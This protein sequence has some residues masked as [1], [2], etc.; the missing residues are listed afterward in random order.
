MWIWRKFKSFCQ[1]VA[2]LFYRS[3]TTVIEVNKPEV[4]TT[5]EVL[6][7]R[8]G[9]EPPSNIQPNIQPGT[10]DGTSCPE[11]N[12]QLYSRGYAVPEGWIEPSNEEWLELGSEPPSDSC[13]QPPSNELYKGLQFKSTLREKI[14]ALR[15]AL[16]SFKTFS[17]EERWD[18]GG[19]VFFR[20]VPDGVAYVRRKSWWNCF[21]TVT[22]EDRL[23]YE[24]LDK[25]FLDYEKLLRYYRESHLSAT[26]DIYK[27]FLVEMN[28]IILSEFKSLLLFITMA[29][30]ELLLL[31]VEQLHP[32][33]CNLYIRDLCNLTDSLI[34]NISYYQNTGLIPP[35]I[36][37]IITFNE[38]IKGKIATS[39]NL[40]NS[41][42]HD[43]RI[44]AIAKRVAQP[45]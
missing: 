31:C 6:R 16:E 34:T 18:Y 41:P 35:E 14:I 5:D 37:E 27:K 7:H 45:F 13:D 4:S 10:T 3:N 39:P 23:D 1:S 26:I 21:T 9:S 42:S 2:R 36:N 44:M 25:F 40:R 15:N 29:E 32:D 33:C 19:N 17:L 12:A 11:N 24:T 43:E 8:L 20:H 30:P 28:K 38:K 22:T